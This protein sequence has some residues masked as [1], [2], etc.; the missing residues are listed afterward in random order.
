MYLTLVILIAV[1]LRLILIYNNW[2]ITNS[3]E[4]NMGILARHVAFNGDRPIFFYGLPYLGPLEGYIA[5]SLFQLF[6][7]SMFLLR[8]ALLPYFVLFLPC[9]YYLTRLLYTRRLAVFVTLLFCFGSQ[10][11]I[12]RQLRAVGEYPETLFFAAFITLVVCWLVLSSSR[13][14]EQ[15]RTTVFRVAIYGILGLVVGCA[16]WVDFLILPILG[17][18]AL[19]LLLFSRREVLSWAGLSLL[20]GIL[21]GAFP[22]LYYNLTAPLSQNS[23]VILFEIQHSGAAQ[24]PPFIQQIVGAVMVSLPDATGFNP[25]CYASAFPYFGPVNASCVVFQG[26]WGIG[27][28]ILWASVTIFTLRVIWQGWK[29]RVIYE[30]G[31]ARQ[32]FVLQCCR[33]MLLVSAGSTIFLYAISPAAAVFPGPTARYLL[34][35]LVA[36]PVLLWPFWNGAWMLVSTTNWQT[37]LITVLRTGVLLLLLVLFVMGTFL[38]FLQ[39]PQAQAAYTRQNRVVQRLLA[40][41]AT[42]IYSEYWTCNNLTFQ[43]EES[44]ICSSLDEQLHPGFDRYAP[45]TAMVRNT[46]YP[47]Y[48]FPQEFAQVALLDTKMHTDSQFSSVYQRSTFEGYVIFAPKAVG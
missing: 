6:G 15:K 29:K 23:L 8:L 1:I 16:L 14:S 42:R 32:D 22:L 33:L 2:P 25:L 43:S 35:V 40:L 9:M 10:E 34:C 36:T 18:S 46:S 7:P 41:H 3:D 38:T 45:Y 5:A 47:S 39:I 48:I 21:I 31:T 11:I 13:I 4:G 17:T 44:I 30:S 37:R 20:A 26:G 19:L 27:Y 28:L 24:H 12:R